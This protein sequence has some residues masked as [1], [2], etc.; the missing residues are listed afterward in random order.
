MP[1]DVVEDAD[2]VVV[3][4]VV[5]VVPAFDL[6]VVVVVLAEPLVAAVVFL[7][8]P[9]AAFFVV[10]FCLTTTL[11]P[12]GIWFS[13]SLSSGE[14]ETTEGGASGLAKWISTSDFWRMF[15]AWERGGEKE[16]SAH[17]STR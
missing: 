3:A 1:P 2:V 13:S 7:A 15:S 6:V 10:L 16:R 4:E 8:E 14:S 11:V 12:L 9:P 17:Y 5:A